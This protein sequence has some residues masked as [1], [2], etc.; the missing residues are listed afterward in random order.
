MDK[1]KTVQQE[2]I[3]PFNADVSRNRGYLYTTN[4]PL[5][6]TYAN[7]RITSAVLKELDAHD[8]RVID[9]GCGDGTFTVELFDRAGARSMVGIDPAQEAIEVA[10]AKKGQRQIEFL[11]NSAYDI[12]WK[13]DSFDI[14]CLR[15]VLHHL[16]RPI[17]AL[18]E[19]LRVAS[20]VVVVEPNG[21]NPGLKLLE[22]FSDYHVKH[23]EE[24]YPPPRLDRWVSQIGGV[25]ISRQ[26]IGFVPFFCPDLIAHALK[27]IEPVIERLPILNRLCCA[28]YVFTAHRK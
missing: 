22:K 14:A 1:I 5:S 28:Q 11:P 2:A 3:A 16:E 25:I 7:Q 27:A 10:Q 19:A 12:P 23:H 17:E 13:T 8:K 15:G 4:A 20:I 6:S 21:Y 18:K 26:W 24:S 9:I